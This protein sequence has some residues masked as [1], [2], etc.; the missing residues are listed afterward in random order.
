V[1]GHGE[2]RAAAGEPADVVNRA[3]NRFSTVRRD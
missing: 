1:P 2:L 3:A